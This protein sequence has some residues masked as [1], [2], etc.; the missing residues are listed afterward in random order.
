MP[1]PGHLHFQYTTDAALVKSILSDP[2]C[3]RRMNN[4]PRTLA[5]LS[6]MDTLPDRLLY[7]VPSTRKNAVFVLS[8]IAPA[9]AEVHFCVAPSAWGQAE[10]IV[11]E[12]LSWIWRT[13]SIARLVGPVPAHNR[14][15]LRIAQKTGFQQIET[16]P[17]AAE[18]NGTKY[19]LLVMEIARAA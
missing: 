16:R 19:D 12:F 14:L 15:A 18:K 9:V 3:F 1:A 8:S 5:T 13:T 7:I 2:R 11:N 6:A 10:Y 17:A 4:D